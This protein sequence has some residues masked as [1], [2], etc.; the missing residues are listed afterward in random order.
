MGGPSGGSCTVFGGR[1]GTG[2]DPPP[3]DGTQFSLQGRN[4]GG[5]HWGLVGAL[6]G[7]EG[8][9]GKGGGGDGTGG[10]GGHLTTGGGGDGGGGGGLQGF[11]HSVHI[12]QDTSSL[13]TAV[14]AVVSGTLTCR[15]RWRVEIVRRSIGMKLAILYAEE[16]RGREHS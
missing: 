15:M 2:I 5:G 9:G 16:W 8:G 13:D 6:G 4:G 12:W 7:G 10:G 11:T 14:V 3:G 1:P